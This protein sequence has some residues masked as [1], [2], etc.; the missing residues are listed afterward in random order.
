[1]QFNFE[2]QQ[3]KRVAKPSLAQAIAESNEIFSENNKNRMLNT[4]LR[5]PNKILN[6]NTTTT[7]K[8]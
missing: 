4:F 1:M 8:F 7:E 3:Q 6:K 5:H 2:L